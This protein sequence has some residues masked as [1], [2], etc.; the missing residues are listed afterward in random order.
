M[1]LQEFVAGQSPEWIKSMVWLGRDPRWVRYEDGPPEEYEM[2]KGVLRTNHTMAQV[3]WDHLKKRGV[4]KHPDITRLIHRT[5]TKGFLLISTMDSVA[6]MLAQGPKMFQPTSE[7]FESMEKVDI[8]IP[9][10][11]FR[12]PYEVTIIQIPPTCRR[13][14]GERFELPPV[15]VPTKALVHYRQAPSPDQIGIVHVTVALPLTADEEEHFVFAIR[16]GSEQDIEE[17]IRRR[18]SKDI[19]V[20][21]IYQYSEDD[22]DIDPVTRLSLVV[23]RAALNLCLMLT[24][25]ELRLKPIN[26]V[27]YERHRRKKHLAHFCHSDVLAIEMKQ[28]VVI[29]NVIQP[30]TGNEPGPGTGI[31]VKPH[32]RRGH[33]R[34]YPGQAVKRAAGEQVQLLFVR[35]CLVRRD[36]MVGDESETEAIYHAEER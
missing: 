36:R 29:R 5:L 20:K 35:P 30:M 11:Q 16:P 1:D 9:T 27:Q 34:C 10:A 18:V 6:T 22:P 28:Q 17:L 19:S 26:P 23:C 33:W 12:S 21:T 4:D 7:Q 32:W 31:E 15:R 25:K 24:T 14:L 2:A 13:R 3:D 8:H